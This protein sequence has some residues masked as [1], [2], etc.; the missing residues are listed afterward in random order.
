VIFRDET[1]V[2]ELYISWTMLC[3]GMHGNI[4]VLVRISDSHVSDASIS[5]FGIADGDEIYRLR[6]GV[7]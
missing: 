1:A 7:F 3:G 2:S 6:L 5:K 4:D